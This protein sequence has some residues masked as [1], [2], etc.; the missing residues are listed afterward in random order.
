MAV[1]FVFRG[2]ESWDTV[3]NLFFSLSVYITVFKKSDIQTIHFIKHGL[4]AVLILGQCLLTLNTL[5]IGKFF[6]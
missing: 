5:K 2:V 6:I 4:I 1:L 3:L